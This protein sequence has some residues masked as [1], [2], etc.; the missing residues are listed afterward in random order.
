EILNLT[1]NVYVRGYWQ[2]EKYFERV[3]QRIRSEVFQ[4]MPL[5]EGTK[6]VAAQIAQSGASAFLHVRRSDSRTP[7]GMAFHGLLGLDY[8]TAAADHIRER[9][10]GVRFFVFSDEP[11]WC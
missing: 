3:Q 6:R 9:V 8:Y 2:C 4:G 1:G 7:G 11:D 5:G 10:P